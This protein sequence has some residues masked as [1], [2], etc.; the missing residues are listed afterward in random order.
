MYAG[1]TNDLNF[2]TSTPSRDRYR[3]IAEIDEMREIDMRER[4]TVRPRFSGYPQSETGLFAQADFITPRRNVTFDPSL[5]VPDTLDAQNPRPS[6]ISRSSAYGDFGQSNFS[7]T[8]TTVTNV[9][10]PQVSSRASSLLGPLTTNFATLGLHTQTTHSGLGTPIHNQPTSVYP[11]NQYYGVNTQTLQSGFGAP[12]QPTGIPLGQNSSMFPLN[13]QTGMSQNAPLLP[14]NLFG[15][16][17]GPGVTGTATNYLTKK[18]IEPPLFNGK[19]EWKSFVLRFEH[20]ALYNGW[21]DITK[22]L[23]LAICLDGDAL[24]YCGTL[25]LVDS[26][27]YT[28]LKNALASRF[29]TPESQN[30]YRSQ[31][32]SRV[33]ND[34]EE[35][36]TYLSDLQ[37]LASKA[38]PKDQSDLYHQL[39]CDQFTQ[40]I[41]NRECRE[42]LQIEMSKSRL[43]GHLLVQEVL[44]LALNFEA[45]RGQLDRPR[46]PITDYDRPSHYAS[47][48]HLGSRNDYA[49]QS[50]Y[51]RPNRYPQNNVDRLHYADRSNPHNP[52]QY[53]HMPMQYNNRPM[54]HS[55]NQTRYD[56]G[57]THQNRPMQQNARFPPPNQRN[58]DNR[59]RNYERSRIIC[60][61]CNRQGHVASRCWYANQEN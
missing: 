20:I 30:M 25:R 11:Q 24:D 33:R 22:R 36:K 8:T 9:L 44:T 60:D 48:Q 17:F 34:N 1:Q 50:D 38:F 13:Y 58:F 3:S 51:P 5:G 2:R 28:D 10:K 54:P 21:D 42:F 6:G 57:P 12:T 31:F 46:K 47:P 40:G 49:R 56:Q 14:Q 32:R 19:G 29:S 16:S 18:E 27:T 45:V 7:N 55:P 52:I 35:I 43:N 53:D 39:I 23:R 41:R 4:S 26:L 15:Q 59:D 37:R 61:I